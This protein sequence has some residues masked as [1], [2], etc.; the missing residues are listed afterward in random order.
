[1]FPYISETLGMDGSM[2]MFASISLIGALFV[3]YFM[4]ETKGLSFEEITE[5]LRK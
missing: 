5:L 2:F 1:M 4:P 3:I